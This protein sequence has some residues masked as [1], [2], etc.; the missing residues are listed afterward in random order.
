M[1]FVMTEGCTVLDEFDISDQITSVSFDSQADM[2]DVTPLKNG[3]FRRYVKGLVTATS[4]LDGM[5]DFAAGGAAVEFPMSGA[6]VSVVGTFVPQGFDTEG[7]RAI[8]HRGLL[9][10]ISAPTGGVGDIAGM[11]ISSRGTSAQS[12]GYVA[13][14]LTSYG[15]GGLTGT[16]I[17]VA[18]PS[19]D[20]TLWAH[21]HVTAASG[22][23]LEVKI[24]SDDNS[25]F[26][27]A[28]DRI[29]FSTVSAVGAQSAS[30][31]GDLSTED[32]WRAEITVAS[33][34]FSCLVVFGIG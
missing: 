34:T 17:N 30:V 28:T 32:Y 12:F 1:A 8:L 9:E 29:T 19:A 3:G 23:D 31:A 5:A 2:V 20:Q 26:T 21:L 22:T 7:D 25:G 6:G 18:G 11:T 27:T 33:G 10:T 4:Q 15:T 24:Q 13:A 14:P 16:G